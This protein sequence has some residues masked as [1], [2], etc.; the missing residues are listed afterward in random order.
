MSNSITI[1]LPAPGENLIIWSRNHGREAIELLNTLSLLEGNLVPYTSSRGRFAISVSGQS[2]VMAFPF[3]NLVAIAN[4]TTN[5]T[6]LQT[7]VVA[8][9]TWMRSVGFEPGTG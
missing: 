8:I 2:A 3:Q 1:P 6:S 9:L 4:P 5:P 7:A